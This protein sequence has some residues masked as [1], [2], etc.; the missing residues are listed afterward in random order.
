M[1]KK[2]IIRIVTAGCMALAVPITA[3]AGQWKENEK[4]WWYDNEDGT[5][6]ASCWKW[7]DGNGDGI[8]ECYYFNKDGYMLAGSK[9]PDGKTV[10][11]E[12]KWIKEGEI[13]TR[14]A[15]SVENQNVLVSSLESKGTKYF[16]YIPETITDIQ[17]NVYT[18]PFAIN[19][20]ERMG[21]CYGVYESSGYVRLRADKIA[22]ANGREGSM[23]EEIIINIYDANTE[24]LLNTTTVTPETENEALDVNIIGSSK[25]R[26][27]ARVSKGVGSSAYVILDNLQLIK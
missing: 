25:I 17:G 22:L 9:A 7:I 23:A 8:A 15:A 1:M 27:S 19:C 13:Q 16:I 24:K 26:I 5:Y 18:K 2:R 6:P 4:G 3:L 10:T 21:N 20:L 11:E 12:G 14:D